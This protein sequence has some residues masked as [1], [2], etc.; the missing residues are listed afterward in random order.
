MKFFKIL[1]I[2]IILVILLPGITWSYEENDVLKTAFLSSGARLESFD[3]VD[4]SVI[5]REFMSFEDMEKNKDRIIKL[6]GGKT[7]N[8]K[9]TK[10]SDEMYRIINTE[11]WLDADTFL[12]V[13]LQSVVLPEEYEREPQT[14]LVVTATSRDMEKLKELQA[15]VRDAITSSGGQSRITTCITG[16]F[17]GKLNEVEQDKILEKFA[18]DLKIEN[19]EQMRDEHTVSLLGFSTQLSDSITIMGHS[20]NV[21]IAIRYNSEDDR[22]YI[23]IGTPVISVEY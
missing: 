11:G 22:T 18:Q 16:T 20:Y 4:W 14:Y 6:F 3:V 9:S 13:I 7:Q 2:G 10:E 21:N 8:F 5:N 19:P 1:L 15:K 12:G 23:W 17:D